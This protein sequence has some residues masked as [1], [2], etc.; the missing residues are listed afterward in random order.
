MFEEAYFGVDGKPCLCKDGYAKQT[1]KYDEKGNEIQIVF[2]DLNDKP[3]I[4]KD[5]GKTRILI[6]EYDEN[7]EM[8]GMELYDLDGNPIE[9][10][11]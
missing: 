5:I 10:W 6:R 1:W 9:I 2:F 11:Q 8:I 7:G 4:S 3:I